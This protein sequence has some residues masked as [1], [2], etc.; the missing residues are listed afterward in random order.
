MALRVSNKSSA[1]FCSGGAHQESPQPAEICWGVGIMRPSSA[2]PLQ[3]FSRAMT[4]AAVGKVT[5]SLGDFT[6]TVSGAE[7]AP[8]LQLLF[9]NNVHIG[10]AAH[11]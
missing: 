9:H 3:A 10:G 7:N 6:R 2:E 4:A 11:R 5:T 8:C 1:S